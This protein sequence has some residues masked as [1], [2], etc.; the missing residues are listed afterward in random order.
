MDR[1]RYRCDWK[2]FFSQYPPSPPP[3]VGV[4]EDCSAPTPTTRATAPAQ[5]AGRKPPDKTKNV[6]AKTK[7]M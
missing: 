2:T 7:E 3:R 1:P 4:E 5:A 6:A